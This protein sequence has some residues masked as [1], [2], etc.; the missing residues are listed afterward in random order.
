MRLRTL[1]GAPLREHLNFNED[2]LLSAAHCREFDVGISHASTTLKWRSVDTQNTRLHT[3]WSQPYLPRGSN[4]LARSRFPSSSLGAGEASAC[5]EGTT[6][7]FETT[8]L[9][10]DEPS[11]ADGFLRQSIIFYNSLLSSQVLPDSGVDNTSFSSTF[12]TSFNTTLSEISAHGEIAL[13]VNLQLPVSIAISPIATL[14]SARHLKS[15]YPQT[16]TPNLLGV[17]MAIPER[18]E[19]VVRKRGHRMTLWEIK[20]ADD[21]YPDFKISF[22]MRPVQGSKSDQTLLLQTLQNL[23]PGDI[24]LLRNIAL[25][26]FRDTVYGQ[27]LSSAITRAKTSIDVLMK[28]NGVMITSVSTLPSTVSEMFM[29]VK[30]WARSHVAVEHADSRKRKASIKGQK[31]AKRLFP[32][33]EHDDSL[34]PDTLEAI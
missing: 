4:R 18:K 24:L 14:P 32:G 3:G 8:V 5:P 20:V 15:I 23:R 6:T 34:P 10:D 11:D 33:P 25:T 13:P 19:V 27:S 30:K 22:W 7:S 16:P 12:M 17:L 1:N 26:S 31:Q 28:S 9:D 21:T 29:R 2:N